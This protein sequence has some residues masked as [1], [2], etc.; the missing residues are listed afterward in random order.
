MRRFIQTLILVAFTA[1]AFG[2]GSIEDL[3]KTEVDNINPV[4][5][6]VIGAGVGSFMFLG[7]VRDESQNPFNG[8]LGYKVNVSTF[9]DNK[10]M[11]RANFYFI[12]GKLS[13][14][15]RSS[16]N[17]LRNNNFS[18]DILVFGVNLNYDFDNFYKK[19]KKLHPFV[20]A[21]FETITF[22][23]K[24]DLSANI[25]GEE[26]PYHYWSDGTIRNIAQTDFPNYPNARLMSRDYTYE[27]DLRADV[28]YGGGEYAQYTFAIPFEFGLDYYLT[29]RMLF[30]IGTSY[31]LTFTDFID[32]VSHENTT[33]V[34]GDKGNDDFMYTYIS[35]HLDLFSSDKTLTVQ[36]LFADVEWDP[37][38]MSDEDNDGWFDGWDQCPETPY[39]VETD[40]TG[41]PLDD[42]FDGIPNYQ[43]DEV[44]SRYGAYV[45]DRGVEISDDEIIALLDMSKAVRREDVDLYV[46]TPSSYANYRRVTAKEIPEKFIGIDTDGD[47]YISFDEMMNAIDLYFD[48]DSELSPED[49][50]ELKDFFFSQ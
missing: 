25:A 35:M 33:G 38:L 43:D 6:P 4:Y 16:S 21:G 26:I 28:D 14:N 9:V 40:T 7:D 8:T 49:L 13:G 18:S 10:H 1:N 36:R 20:S 31:H 44:N 29:D 42:D 17:L 34:I 27:T 37:T 48:F 30:R 12:G 50:Q 5:K 2:Q 32:H 11:I 41:C 39:G 19:Y 46:R 15:E 24:T 47:A 45:D 3:L 23:S 22:S